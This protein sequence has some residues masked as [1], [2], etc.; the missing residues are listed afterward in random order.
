[1]T[2]PAND[3]Y[4]GPWVLPIGRTANI[5][6]KAQAAT[7]APTA[8]VTSAAV[9]LYRV[10]LALAIVTAGT[11]GSLTLSVLSTGDNGIQV[12]QSLA[13]VLVT[14]PLGIAQDS[15][16]CEV[17]FASNLSYQVTGIG[18]TVGALQYTVRVVVEKVSSLT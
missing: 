3:N 17:G 6:L 10:T 14:A 2:V 18:L 15:F 13:S 9:G 5:Y 11:A 1:M 16:I 8:A 4:A 12:T 7:I